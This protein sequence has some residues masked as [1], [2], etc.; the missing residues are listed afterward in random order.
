MNV[1]RILVLLVFIGVVTSC[2]NDDDDTAPE[3]VPPREL[4]EVAAEN[5]VEIRAFLETHSYNYEEFENPEEGFDFQIRI[6]TLDGSDPSRTPLSE[7]VVSRTVNVSSSEFLIDGEEDVEHTYYYLEAR[8][9]AGIKPTVADS[10]FVNYEGSL[11]NGLVFD[12]VPTGIWW[13]NPSFQFSGLGSQRAFRGVAE[14]V[15]NI[16]SG[17]SITDNGD[18]T[19]EVNGSGVGMII[20]PS[21]LAT[22]NGIRGSIDAYSPL[23]F[24]IEV[25]VVVAETDHDND[26]VPSI[27]EDVDND[28]LLPSDNTDGDLAAN[29]QDDDDD[30]DGTPTRQEIIIDAEGNITFPDTDGDGTPNYLDPDDSQEVS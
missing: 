20:F 11:L 23:I 21:A 10:T 3:V 16:A 7:Q 18:G 22:F 29:Y 15:T 30:G 6:D 2:N 26:G 24:K 28:G 25:L 9:G 19:T 5:D 12:E 8:P 13:D 27:A 4:R 14:G 1:K 17:S